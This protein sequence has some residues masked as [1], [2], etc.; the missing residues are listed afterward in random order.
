[1]ARR[2]RSDD[3]HRE[4]SSVIPL[5]ALITGKMKIVRVDGDKMVGA[6]DLDSFTAHADL[7]S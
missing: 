2:V 5:H 1:M 4:Q 7:L 6:L 3:V